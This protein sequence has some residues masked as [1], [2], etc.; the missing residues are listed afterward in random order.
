M[1]LKNKTAVITGCSKGIGLSILKKFSENSCNIISCTRVKDEEFLDQCKTI[2]KK[3]K[4][5]IYNFFCDMENEEHVLT[6]ANEIANKFEKIDILVNNAGSN[7]TSLIQMT[8]ADDLHK[9][10]QI[11]YFSIFLFTQII[12]KNMMRNK[13]GNIINISSSAAYD[14][15]I[16]RAVYSASKSALEKFSKTLSKEF[17]AFNIRS[18]VI[19]PG[20]IETNMMKTSTDSKKLEEIIKKLPSKRVGK[21]EEIAELALFLV[22][23]KSNYINGQIVRA[24]GGLI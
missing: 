23:E 2:M 18:N 16:G 19:A 9:I 22:L 3:Y 6:T 4:I 24:D 12:L 1:S 11:N 14:V 5:N 15:P 21:P 17:S 8:K 10:F 20:L 13:S 7:L